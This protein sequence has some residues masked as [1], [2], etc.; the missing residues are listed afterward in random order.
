MK[1][2]LIFWLA[3]YPNFTAAEFVTLKDCEY[4]AKEVKRERDD[5]RFRHVCVPKGKDWVG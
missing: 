4:A 1:F 2:I 3:G 5:S